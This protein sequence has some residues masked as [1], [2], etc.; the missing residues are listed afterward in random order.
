M[1]IIILSPL[2]LFHKRQYLDSK[3]QSLFTGRSRALSFFMPFS[4]LATFFTCWCFSWSFFNIISNGGR[5]L[6]LRQLSIW[7][8]WWTY[9]CLPVVPI[10]EFFL[11]ISN[12]LLVSQHAVNWLWDLSLEPISE[13]FQFS[14]WCA[15][16]GVEHF[17]NITIIL[18]DT[19]FPQWSLSLF[20]LRM[21]DTRFCFALGIFL[22]ISV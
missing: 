7:T 11:C 8:C 16:Q 21:R 1:L 15:Y 17:S 14:P 13:L 2:S 3:C 12:A 18:F 4:G 10:K 9:C 19:A 22:L 6:K 5:V 20:G